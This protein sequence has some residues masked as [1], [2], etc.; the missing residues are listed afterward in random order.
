M[1]RGEKDHGERGSV[2]REERS[3]IG[4]GKGRGRGKRR[5]YE[6]RGGEEGRG[7]T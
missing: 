1:E 3:G 7:E 2:R 4:R 5:G 6:D